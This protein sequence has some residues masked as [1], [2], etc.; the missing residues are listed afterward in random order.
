MYTMDNTQL[1]DNTNIFFIIKKV[2]LIQLIAP[3]RIANT[4][5]AFANISANSKENVQ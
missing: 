3:K 4:A 5:T 1:F 2:I